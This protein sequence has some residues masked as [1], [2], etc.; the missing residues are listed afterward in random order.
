MFITN[1][2]I[3]LKIN[4]DENMQEYSLINGIQL[5]DYGNQNIIVKGKR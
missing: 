1:S 4:K 5:K 2:L 3:I